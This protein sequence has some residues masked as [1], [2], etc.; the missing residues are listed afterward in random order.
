MGGVAV[1]NALA[2]LVVFPNKRGIIVS[3]AKTHR[4]SIISKEWQ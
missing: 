1:P 3:T 4:K 2:H